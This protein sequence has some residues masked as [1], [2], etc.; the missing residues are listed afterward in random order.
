MR[1]AD[2]AEYGFKELGLADDVGDFVATTL[3]ENG[4]PAHAGKAV[5]QAYQKFEAAKL[6]E[7]MS[8]EGYKK[9]M[10]ARFGEGYEAVVKDVVAFQ[11]QH[12]SPESQKLFENLP[13]NVL[14]A[15][16]E[17]TANIQKAFGAKETGAQGG[18]NKGAPPA[19]QDMNAVRAAIRN[20]I[21]ALKNRPHHASEA[22]ALQDKLN[23]TYK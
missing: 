11:K 3:F 10:S 21:Q 4:I 5:V 2:K 17:Y 16:H 12:L 13:N 22:Q 9:E 20:E 7:A 8:A 1:P 23:A 15:F 14:A 6:A 18:D 19:A